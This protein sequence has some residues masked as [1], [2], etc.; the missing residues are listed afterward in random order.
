MTSADASVFGIAKQT[1]KGTPNTTDAEFE[2]HPV[3]GWNALRPQNVNRPLDREV[4]GDA[5][6]RGTAK[7]GV[8]SGAEMQF[9]PRPHTLGK[10]FYAWFGQEDVTADARRRHRRQLAA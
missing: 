9:I 8:M 5:L 7:V 3:H 2:L 1:A 4:G 10:L 6:P